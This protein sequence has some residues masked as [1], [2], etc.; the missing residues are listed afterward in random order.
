MFPSLI[1]NQKAK[2]AQVKLTISIDRFIVSTVPDGGLIVAAQLHAQTDC[3]LGNEEA[4]D[5]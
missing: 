4:E 2:S 1:K 3:P 5:G